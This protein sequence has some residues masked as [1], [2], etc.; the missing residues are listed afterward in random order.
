MPGSTSADLNTGIGK[1]I[2]G[3][4]SKE[5]RHDG[6]GH[7]TKQGSGLAAQGVAG[8]DAVKKGQEGIRVPLD[9]VDK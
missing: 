1:P 2:Q 8:T 9:G 3:Q 6:Q 5:L 4:S 7:N